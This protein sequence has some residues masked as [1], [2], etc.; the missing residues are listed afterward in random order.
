[1]S[2]RLEQAAPAGFAPTPKRARGETL[3]TALA[4]LAVLSAVLAVQGRVLWSDQVAV[5]ADAYVVPPWSSLAPPGGSGHPRLVTDWLRYS[6]PSWHLAHE[7]LWQGRLPLWNPYVFSGQD[8]AATIQPAVFSPIRLALSLLPPGRGLSLYLVLHTLL[9]G[10]GM[11]VWLRSRGTGAAAAAAGALVAS[12]SGYVLAKLGQPTIGATVAWLPLLLWLVDRLLERPTLRLGAALGAAGALC[13]LTGH[14]QLFSLVALAV[15]V[16]AVGQI[17]RLA[18]RASTKRIAANLVLAAALALTASSPQLVAYLLGPQGSRAVQGDRAPPPLLRP[19]VEGVLSL[20]APEPFGSP[21]EGSFRHVRAADSLGQPGKR[22]IWH[23]GSFLY[24][25]AITLLAIPLASSRLRRHRYLPEALVLIGV[26]YAVVFVD[27][28]ADAVMGLPGFGFAPIDRWLALG[29]FGWALTAAAGVDALARDAPS[30][31]GLLIAIGAG[32]SVLLL[33][34]A[35]WL[36][37]LPDVGLASL[38]RTGLLVLVGGAALGICLG[39]RSARR[40]LPVVALVLLGIDLLPLARSY[41]PAADASEILPPTRTTH[42][43]QAHLGPARIARVRTKALRVNTGTVFG[44]RDLQGF[45]PLYAGDYRALLGT[46]HGRWPDARM[47]PSLQAP[48][49]LGSPLLPLLGVRYLI[50]EQPLSH[51]GWRTAFRGEGLT[52]SESRRPAPR[53]RVFGKARWV[54]SKEAA[55]RP[56]TAEGCSLLDEL[57]LI[58][59]VEGAEE[60]TRGNDVG[61]SEAGRARILA[62]TPQRVKLRVQAPAGGW[63]LLADTYHPAWKARVNGDEQPVLRAHLTLRA[64]RVP[65]GKSAVVFEYRPTAVR[66]AA[67]VGLAGWGA[68]LVLATLPAGRLWRVSR[69]RVT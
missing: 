8:W 22:R 37:P 30:R 21:A 10:L 58:E 63:L 27:P 38:A 28:L 66:A 25:G 67:S 61:V 35:A 2:S 19:R 62:E 46:C 13:F 57:I 16:F 40:A 47:V 48:A 32:L 26:S 17:A 31:A 36:A 14:P 52:L 15:L 34:A 39:W 4:A 69:W 7:E 60:P 23:T 55:R 9:L 41:F 5:F 50:S 42:F 56:L 29:A 1:M 11:V 44:L 18:E 20:L 6:Y 33:G 43:L 24:P 3:K 53:A 68:I 65:P 49:E 59:P 54:N 51:P 64:V 45:A 12:L